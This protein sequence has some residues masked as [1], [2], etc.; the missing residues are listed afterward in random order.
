MRGTIEEAGQKILDKEF[1]RLKNF[2]QVICGAV[3][4]QG[5]L[6]PTETIKNGIRISPVVK[7]DIGATTFDLALDETKKAVQYILDNYAH[8]WMRVMPEYHYDP[9]KDEHYIRFRAAYTN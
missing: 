6:I 9:N 4:W 5:Y 3:P 7:H 1:E 8:V 2:P